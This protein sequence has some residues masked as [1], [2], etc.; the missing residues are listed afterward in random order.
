[1]QKGMTVWLVGLPGSGRWALAYALERKLFDLGR[2]ATVV[3][4]RG[5]DLRS[6]ISAAKAASDAGLVTVCAFPSYQRGDRKKIR[7]GIGENRTIMVHVNTRAEICQQR[8][9]N[10]QN[11][12]FEAPEHAEVTV[13]LDTLDLDS[14]VHAILKMLEHHATQTN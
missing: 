9:P 5:E 14:G 13:N 11:V 1:G 3:D 6:M 12:T 4:P 10:A 8:R 7:E 2:T